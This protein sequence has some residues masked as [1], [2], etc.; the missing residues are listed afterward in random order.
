MPSYEMINIDLEMGTKYLINESAYFLGGLFAA[1]EA[2]TVRE[3]KYYIAPVRHNSGYLTQEELEKH[4]EHV[5]A[6]SHKLSNETL[7]SQTIKKNGFDSG[8]FNRLQGFG[9][10][11]KTS[12]IET[13]EDMIPEVKRALFASSREVQRS[14]IVGM[15]D[16][17]GSIDID[18]NTN[19]I[20]Y[21]VLDCENAVVGRF[22]CDVV[23][24]YGMSHNYNQA[25][26]RL[27]GGR[28]RKDQLRIPGAENFVLKIGF[29]SEKKFKVAAS[30]YPD[31]YF[32]IQEE[33]SILDGL[34]TLE[35]K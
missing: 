9:T 19:N 20:R 11:F 22:L 26:E 27:E 34:K 24:N 6:I 7:M 12:G 15:F 14:F 28:P 21:V 16:G 18:K 35:R 5:K 25:R 33:D 2:V 8:K 29:I 32:K 13:I 23:G 31:L 10:F 3:Q 1:N 30:V 17:R 4:F